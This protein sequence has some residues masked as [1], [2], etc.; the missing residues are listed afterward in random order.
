M[1]WDRIGTV[2]MLRSGVRVKSAYWCKADQSLSQLPQLILYE[3]LGHTWDIGVSMFWLFA[4]YVPLQHL[5]LRTSG[6][7]NENATFY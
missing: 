1:S 3:L 6:N 2:F 5:A 4:S 7:L